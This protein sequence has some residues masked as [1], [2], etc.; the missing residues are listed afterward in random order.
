M[1]SRNVG[2]SCPDN[3]VA[4]PAAGGGNKSLPVGDWLSDERPVHLVLTSCPHFLEW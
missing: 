1:C 3:S 2:L 4:L